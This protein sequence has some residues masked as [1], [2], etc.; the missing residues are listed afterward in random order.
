MK[1]ILIIILFFSSLFS[2]EVI[3]V[4][5]SFITKF[6]YGKMLYTNPRG[7]GCNSCHGDDAKGKDIVKFTH[8]RKKK[9]YEC[10]LHAPS[11]KDVSYNKFYKKVN[12]KKNRKKKFD[13]EEVC[14]KLIY[15]ANVMP[16]YFLVKEEIEAIYHY[17]NN[18]K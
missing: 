9:N 18:L 12:S 17:V 6:E 11:I 1:Y 2:N 14:K 7:I 8:E 13:K 15:N 4:D 10:V 3:Q 16:T 5:N